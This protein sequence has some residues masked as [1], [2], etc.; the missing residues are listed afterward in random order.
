MKLQRRT[1]NILKGTTVSNQ[2]LR[3]YQTV[4]SPAPQ[5]LSPLTK[6]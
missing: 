2:G 3:H 1:K 5:T 4:N 6:E